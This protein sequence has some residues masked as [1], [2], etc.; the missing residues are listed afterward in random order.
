MPHQR[1]R[2][3]YRCAQREIHSPVSEHA[4]IELDFRKTTVIIALIALLKG[5]IIG[6]ALRRK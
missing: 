6:L 5:L 4:S 3:H 1:N 2:R